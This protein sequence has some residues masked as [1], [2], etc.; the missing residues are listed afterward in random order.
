MS[1]GPTLEEA[2][3]ALLQRLAELR[4]RLDAI[5]SVAKGHSSIAWLRE[6]SDALED[7]TVMI[8]HAVMTNAQPSPLTEDHIKTH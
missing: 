8:D 3:A 4:L 1:N 7:S 6:I 5:D 2:R